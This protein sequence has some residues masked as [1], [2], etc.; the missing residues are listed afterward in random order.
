MDVSMLD[1][2][3][4]CKLCGEAPD[5]EMGEFWDKIKNESVIAHAQCGIDAGLT[6]A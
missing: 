5:F 1:D 3:D 6:L 2:A 4:D